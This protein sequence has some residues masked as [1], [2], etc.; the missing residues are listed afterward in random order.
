MRKRLSL[1]K[2]AIT[3]LL[4]SALLVGGAS[5]FVSC[6]DNESDSAYDTSVSQ[7]A[8]L[9]EL[10]KWLGELKETNPDLK[11]AIDA[12]IQAN[13]DRICGNAFKRSSNF[14]MPFLP[15]KR[16]LENA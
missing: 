5:T 6:T 7:I 1:W 14:K 11:S 13:M 15:L 9:T 16:Y 3:V 8:K 12:R 2:N 4:F 10:N